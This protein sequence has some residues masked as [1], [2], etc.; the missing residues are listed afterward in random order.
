[1]AGFN[2]PGDSASP[3]HSLTLDI[4]S[5]LD[6]TRVLESNT[7][8]VLRVAIVAMACWSLQVAP[9]LC[10]AGVLTHDCR[11]VSSGGSSDHCCDSYDGPVSGP[12]SHESNCSSDPCSEKPL[13]RNGIDGSLN[14]V[15]AILFT[16]PLG[17]HKF[18]EEAGFLRNLRQPLSYVMTV[19]YHA[20]DLPLRV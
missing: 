2:P 3:K 18:L 4:L 9:A 8:M 12:C 17:I 14:N 19:A 10:L 13:I 5:L 20:S 6:L 15:L 11:P 16:Q 7:C 1:M